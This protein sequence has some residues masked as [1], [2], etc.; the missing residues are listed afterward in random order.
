MKVSTKKILFLQLFLFIVLFFVCFVFD[1]FSIKEYGYF[2]VILLTLLGAIGLLGYSKVKSSH[3]KEVIIST[4]VFTLLFQIS[5][6]VLFG[7]KLGFL[8]SSYSFG[9]DHL[10]KIVLPLILIIIFSEILRSQMVDKGRSSKI[11][12]F[13]TILL[14]V[15]IDFFI[16]V[17]IYNISN[18]KG[19]FE[20]IFFVVFPSLIKNILLTYITYYFGY[21]SNIVYRILM[22]ISIY[23]LPI[24]P[25][26]SDYVRSVIVIVFS[27]LLL[28]YFCYYVDRSLIIRSDTIKEKSNPY[29]KYI[30]R[31]VSIILVVFT[32]VFAGLM[33]GIFKFYFLAVGSGSMHPEINMGDMVL[34]EKVNDLEKI[35]V[36]QVLVYRNRDKV[37][38]HR[39]IEVN[40]NAGEITFKTKGDNNKKADMWVVAQNDVI[41]ITKLKISYFG[42]PTIWLNKLFNGGN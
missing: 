8:R 19:L 9:L 23:Y 36:G 10:F 40:N 14:F 16:G 24:Y 4:V 37:I 17:G 35:E 7:L 11:V 42:Y 5:V 18:Y 41:G 2:F 39:I 3:N 33:S 26:I 34:V 20:I 31:I 32:L 13:T 30:E 38:L 12:I 22:E 21:I 27:F 28:I 6:F 15:S 1:I 29:F 25:D